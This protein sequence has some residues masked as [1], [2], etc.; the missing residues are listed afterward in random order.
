MKTITQ[1]RDDI[2]KDEI[3]E[4]LCIKYGQSRAEIVKSIENHRHFKKWLNEQ[5]SNLLDSKKVLGF[6]PNTWEDYK[7]FNWD[8]FEEK[9]QKHLY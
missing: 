4:K 3:I 1:I 2:Y 6:L 5:H 7:S 8:E 9:I